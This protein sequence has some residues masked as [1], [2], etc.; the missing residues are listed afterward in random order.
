V[1]V[2]TAAS[3]ALAL[4]SGAMLGVG[5]ARG[6]WLLLTNVAL[7]CSTL[8]GIVFGQ[9]MPPSLRQVVHPFFVSCGATAAMIVATSTAAGLPPTAVLEVFSPMQSVGA[10]TVLSRLLGPT[11]IAYALPMYAY[12]QLMNCAM[13]QIALCVAASS[14]GS[15][16][17]SALLVRLAGFAA[18]LRL[19]FFP[20]S[21]SLPFALE[22]C[23][24]LGAT[25]SVALFPVLT[26]GLTG[27]MVGKHLMSRLGIT[28]PAARG[29][30]G[31]CA[32]HGGGVIAVQDE[33]E[34]LPFAVVSMALTGAVTMGLLCIP[35]IR[36][37]LI[38]LAMGAAA[39]KTDM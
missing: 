38:T 32:S 25:K 12:R 26:S 20:R 21:L 10:G 4:R 19:A 27:I 36:N 5:V 30:A 14:V 37:A 17:T 35:T 33:D 15:L 39:L 23:D 29:L 2:L 31:G 1:G 8:F 13:V 18:P 7:M 28:D 16:V 3:G 22:A 34:A 11:I 9:R 24:I 6:S